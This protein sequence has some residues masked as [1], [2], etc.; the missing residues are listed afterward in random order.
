[1]Y[2]KQKREGVARALGLFVLGVSVGGTPER[3][4]AEENSGPGDSSPTPI[5]DRPREGVP[6]A[7]ALSNP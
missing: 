2:Q 7:I 3:F 5:D 4:A 1:M 6:P